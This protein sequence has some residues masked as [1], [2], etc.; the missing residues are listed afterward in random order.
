MALVFPVTGELFGDAGAHQGIE[1]RQAIAQQAGVFPFPEWRRATQGQQVRQEVIE[2]VHQVD[3]QLIIRNPDV[4]VH[5]AD[6]QAPG[7]S[8]HIVLQ[9]IVAF[10]RRRQLLMPAAERMGGSGDGGET[11][12]VGNL[13]DRASQRG[14][15]GTG[16]GDSSAWPGAHLDLGTQEFRGDLPSA[17]RRAF[18]HHGAGRVIAQVPRRFIHQQVF[19]LDA[20]AEFRFTDHH[21]VYLDTWGQSKKSF[22]IS[23][24]SKRPG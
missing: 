23:I 21:N 11:V 6:Q 17:Q 4:D 20:D 1:H 24:H 10:L 8:L 5:A 18:L 7:R 16:L 22:G 13:D 15:V 2:L 19:F 14:K 12:A 9:D 3:A